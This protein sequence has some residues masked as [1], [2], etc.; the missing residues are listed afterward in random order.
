M[1]ILSGREVRKRI[2]E[3]IKGGLEGREFGVMRIG[4]DPG[5]RYYLSGIRKNAEKLGVRLDVFER[6]KAAWEE[7]ENKIEEWKRRNI[8]V[9]ILQPVPGISPHEI[10]KIIPPELDV[11]GLHPWNMGLL[12][13]GEAGIFPPTPQA[14]LEILSFYEIE[15]KG[16]E[17]VIVGRSSV[18]GRP[19][20]MMLLHKGTWDATVTVAHSRTR[21]LFEV[22]RRGDVVVVAAGSP[23][24]LKR[25]GVKEG[26]CVI[27]VGINEVSGKVCGDVDFED[28]KEKA[29]AITPV[30]GGVGS[31]TSILIFKNLLKIHEGIHGK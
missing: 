14:V 25:E 9:L 18:V 7:I 2:F 4:D 21:N 31:V 27:D 8:P 3:E 16:K 13:R 12:L 17:V 26:A 20:S 29:G 15:T 24:L 10:Y 28:V 5:S 11:E 22:T 30:P 19:L 6:E 23:M 1:R